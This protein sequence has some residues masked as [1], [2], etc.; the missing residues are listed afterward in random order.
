MM[1]EIRRSAVIGFIRDLGL[2]PDEVTELHITPSSVRVT[3]LM[4]L[5]PVEVHVNEAP[6]DD[7]DD[8]E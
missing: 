3:R 6:E 4:P 5:G 1:P 2:N 7:G 8:D